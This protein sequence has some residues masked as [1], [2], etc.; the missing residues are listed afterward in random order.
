MSAKTVIFKNAAGRA[1]HAFL[2]VGGVKKAVPIERR[3]CPK[4]YCAL[5][6]KPVISSTMRCTVYLPTRVYRYVLALKCTFRMKRKGRIGRTFGLA[7]S[8]CVQMLRAHAWKRILGADF[9][10]DASKRCG[11]IG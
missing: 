11:K 8:L 9:F 1:M 7:C 3:G 5:L 10:G 2:V 4:P 6:L